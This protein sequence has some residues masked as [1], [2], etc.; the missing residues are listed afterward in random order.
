MNALKMKNVHVTTVLFLESFIYFHMKNVNNC[1][2]CTSMNFVEKPKPLLP[3]NMWK[4]INAFD[5]QIII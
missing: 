2:T 4:R 1:T 3:K 5:V